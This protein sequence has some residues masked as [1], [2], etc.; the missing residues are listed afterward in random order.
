MSDIALQHPDFYRIIYAHFAE[1]IQ[2]RGY[3]VESH[4]VTTKDG[5]ILNMFRIPY[6][7]KCRIPRLGRRRRSACPYSLCNTG[8]VEADFG[9]TLERY[10]TAPPRGLR[11]SWKT[12]EHMRFIF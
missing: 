8:V 7:K 10:V 9:R 1:M 2:T 6:G 12:K 11:A 5:Y 3:P 4:F